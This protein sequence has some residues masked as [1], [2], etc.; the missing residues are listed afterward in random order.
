MSWIDLLTIN[1]LNI[2]YHAINPALLYFIDRDLLDK[3]VASI[4]NL[5]EL[6]EPKKIII[7]QQENG[8]WKYPGN[9]TNNDIGTN[10]ALIETFRTLRYL[11]EKYGFNHAHPTLQKAAEYIFSCQTSEGDIRGILSN[12]YM[13]YY[14]GAILELLIKAGYDKDE[15]LIKGLDWLLS[16]RQNDGAWFIPLQ[17][18]KITYIYQVAFDDPIPP[19]RTKPFSHLA[20]GMILRAFAAHPQYRFLPEIKKAGNLLKS[21]ILKPD[22]YNDHKAIKYWT[23]FQFPF[24]WTDLISALDSLFKLGFDREDPDVAKG[25]DWFIQNQGE[26]GLWKACYE[27][28]PEMDLWVSLA[29]CRVLKNYF[30][31]LV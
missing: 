3:K 20:T 4:E 27:K 31:E 29:A 25:L 17:A 22:A 1:P 30:G 18:Y 5:W 10:Y 2:L 14:V 11:V 15:R 7:K 28:R 23:N 9:T 16:M 21:R 19:D 8:S 12:Q 24:W 6:P 26:N 13:P